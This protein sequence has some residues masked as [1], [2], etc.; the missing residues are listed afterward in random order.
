MFRSRAEALTSSPGW[1]L[2]GPVSHVWKRGKPRS[3]GVSCTRGLYAAALAEGGASH[4]C[5][6]GRRLK[7]AWPL[8]GPSPGLPL[9]RR[10]TWAFSGSPALPPGPRHPWSRRRGSPGVRQAL[11]WAA[12][13]DRV[14]LRM[15]SGVVEVVL[16]EG[17]P[18]P[19]AD[20]PRRS[21]GFQPEGVNPL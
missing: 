19:R 21:R 15:L 18:Q 13:P 4:P 6:N 5:G 12:W 14:Q 1:G 3:P 16:Q 10:W 8:I 2:K 7:R 9:V 20:L 17:E 11:H